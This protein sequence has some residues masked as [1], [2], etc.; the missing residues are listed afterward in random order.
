VVGGNVQIGNCTGASGVSALTS[1]GG[2]ITIMGDFQCH[3]DT[4]MCTAAGATIG[5]NVQ[6]NNNTGTASNI[7]DNTIF[8][9]LQ[10]QNNSPPPFHNAGPNTVT[11]NKQGQCSAA[12]GF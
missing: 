10:C 8:K 12:L 6:V 4:E 7:T 3:N 2:P 5:G 9:D 1:F 11:G